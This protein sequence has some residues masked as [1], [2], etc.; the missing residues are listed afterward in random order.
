MQHDDL[1][2]GT[3]AV[4]VGFEEVAQARDDAQDRLMGTDNVVGVGLGY[5]I[6]NGVQTDTKSVMVLV[7]EKLP[8]SMLGTSQAL[9]KTVSKVTTDVVDVGHVF[10]GGATAMETLD[11][12][13]LA[14]R[15]RPVRPGYSVGHFKIT[16]GTIG[17]GCYDLSPVPGKPPRYYILSN[18]HVLANSN[19]ANI[20]DPIYQPGPIDGGTA[21][22][23]VGRLSRFVPIKF[24]GSCNA[25]DAA[26]A[27]VPFDTLDRDIYW[28]GYP[29]SAVK[30]A[31]VGQ[32]LKKT[33]RTTH[34]TTG[35]VTAVNATINVNYGGGNVA[36]FCNQIVTTDMSAG[37]DSG[38]LVLDLENNPVG[39]L[40]A[41]SSTATILNPIANVQLAL[42]VRV[43]P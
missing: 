5:K 36:K 37:G 13:S 8:S 33:G 12:Q 16:A 18:N 11:A 31:A 34:F 41:G 4:P 38:S 42:K 29:T 1:T 14:K 15:V 20:G 39:L 21:A 35:R 23:A 25:V 27:E 26:I 40:F 10:A 7:T 2:A 22:D 32:L 19:Q 9:P 6:S 28:T 43:W 17:A 3:E 30:V 24:D